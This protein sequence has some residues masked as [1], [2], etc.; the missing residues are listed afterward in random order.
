MQ[1]YLIV[2]IYIYNSILYLIKYY[3]AIITIQFLEQFWSS[4]YVQQGN[5][6]TQSL[7]HCISLIGR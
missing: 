1:M 6:S 4:F 2:F 7:C 5:N 3:V